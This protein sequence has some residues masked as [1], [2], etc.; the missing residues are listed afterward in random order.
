MSSFY[1]ITDYVPKF[2]SLFTVSKIV[3][4]QFEEYNFNVDIT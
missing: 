1:L 2:Q 3:C 4:K